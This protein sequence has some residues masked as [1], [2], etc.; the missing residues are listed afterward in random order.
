MNRRMDQIENEL[1][2]MKKE[3]NQATSAEEKSRK[4]MDDLASVL[5]DV[6]AEASEAKE[7]LKSTQVELKSTKDKLTSEMI[8]CNK[9]KNEVERL[10][11]EAD[12]TLVAWNE[13][14][15]GLVGCIKKVEE[16]RSR[17]QAENSVLQEEM[18]KLRDILKQAMVEATGAK[19]AAS[20]ARAENCQL[21]DQLAEKDTA[22]NF[23]SRE[24]ESLRLSEAAARDNLKNSGHNPNTQNA[25]QI[26]ET[27]PGTYGISITDGGDVDKK[28]GRAFSFDMRC[29]GRNKRLEDL[30]DEKATKV[31]RGDASSLK[32]N[33]SCRFP[34]QT[35]IGNERHRLEQGQD[36]LRK[37]A[38]FKRFGEALGAKSSKSNLH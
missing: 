8:E 9:C 6:A 34:D 36:S 20:I 23:V 38:L 29:T 12:E 13:K 35:R 17:A 26:Q 32:R 19:E 7:K 24:L 2:K 10:R 25:E 11:L 37:K 4:A 15:S 1:K 27:M 16:E 31:V 21:K 5:R 22:L 3:L 30:V 28:I 18:R 33:M 14:E